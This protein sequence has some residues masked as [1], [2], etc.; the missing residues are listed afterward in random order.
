M[1]HHKGSGTVKPHFSPT[2]VQ[3]VTAAADW[4]QKD[5]QQY[6]LSLVLLCSRQQ[7]PA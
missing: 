5:D 2:K 1:D 4:L 7:N 6:L 3:S